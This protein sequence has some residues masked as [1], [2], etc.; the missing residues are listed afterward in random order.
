MADDELFSVRN[1]FALGLYQQA[2]TGAHALL[3]TSVS[4]RVSTGDTQVHFSVTP[5][6]DILCIV[7]LL[8]GAQ[9][10]NKLGRQ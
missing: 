1:S 4:F 3:R 6:L 2:I 5:L 8:R 9:C 7:L 10:E